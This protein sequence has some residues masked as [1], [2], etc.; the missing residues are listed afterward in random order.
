MVSAI[1]SPSSADSYVTPSK[2]SDK[3]LWEAV[4]REQW[5]R[6]QQRRRMV[7][8]RLQKKESVASM[9]QERRQLERKL[10]QHLIEARVAT[11]GLVPKTID[12]AFRLS[13]I[14][15][16][17]LKRENLI[18]QE[19]VA[20]HMKF[21]ALLGKDTEEILHPVSEKEFTLKPTTSPTKAK[22]KLKP[23]PLQLP[24]DGGWHVHFPNGE[25]SFY[26]SPFTRSHFDEIL[27][28]NDVEYA[29]RHPCTA[30]VGKILGW[31]VNYAPLAASTSGSSCIAH[32]R[33]TKQLKCSLDKAKRVLPHLDKKL[34]PV[35][36]AQRSWGRVQS[37]DVH[38][39]VLQ[40][41]TK[42]D[43][44]IAYN[45]PGPVNLRY[46]ALAR[47][48]RGTNAEGQRVDKYILTIG[49]S[50]SNANNR[51]VEDFQDVQWVLEGGTYMT[52]TEVD[53]E[54][55]NIVFDNWA[56]CLN[57]AHGRELYVDW[58]RFPFGLEQHVSP[59]SPSRCNL[60][61]LNEKLLGLIFILASGPA[62]VHHIYGLLIN[63]SELQANTPFTRPL[64]R[65]KGILNTSMP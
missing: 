7:R 2:K 55:I 31:N 5:R 6:E 21:E 61:P 16:A 24:S 10:H 65:F 17:S 19:T 3:A 51:D 38:C 43:H 63:F 25:P 64:N 48:V 22:A 46:I 11:D 44:V 26:F 62:V 1:L 33:F 42:N 59:L 12:E 39:Q 37:G 29:Q 60:R 27:S 32:T 14:E 58:V 40:S 15:L 30:T 50:K 41:F 49:D 34:W 53:A 54:T 45:I 56:E 52:I 35:L 28:N 18:L 13:T 20:Q 4:M 47:S 23:T 36:A 57:E 9:L 8:W